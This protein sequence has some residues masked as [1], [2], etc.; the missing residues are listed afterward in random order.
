MTSQTS[1]YNFYFRATK[2]KKSQRL[3]D[4]VDVEPALP[5]QQPKTKITQP[6]PPKKSTRQKTKLKSRPMQEQS[7][8]E[9]AAKVKKR[10]PRTMGPEKKRSVDEDPFPRQH[11]GKRK[12]KRTKQPKVEE[13]VPKI[14][15]AFLVPDADMFQQEQPK[16]LSG[17]VA[18][19]PSGTTLPKTGLPMVQGNS[20]NNGVILVN[21]QP[22]WFSDVPPVRK[23]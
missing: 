3:R 2:E 7:I 21:G 9:L 10:K 11:V 5:K 6:V 22:F 4:T 20:D 19:K 14:D 17:E 18:V 1:P 13:F 12:K 8:I 16:N 15:S 23:I